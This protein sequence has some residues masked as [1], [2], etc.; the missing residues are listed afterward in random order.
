[1][2]ANKEEAA[3]A[4]ELAEK[5]LLMGDYVGARKMALKA[6]QL[7]PD[8]DNLSRLLVVCDVHC[9]AASKLNGSDSDWYAIL[10][11][12]RFSDETVIL[13]QYRK[14]A[15]SLHPDKNKYAGAEAA[16]K[17][18]GEA[19][20]ELT[21]P[22]RRALFDAKCRG[23]AKSA[24]P[25]VAAN[26]KGPGKKPPGAFHQDI[27]GHTQ[28]QTQPEIMKSHSYKQ[29]QEQTFWTCCQSCKV[30][31]QYYTQ[32]RNKM[33][34]CQ[35][36]NQN[37]VA[38]D[39]VTM[40]VPPRSANSGSASHQGVNVQG[41][42]NAA[43]QSNGDKSTFAGVDLR[44]NG[45]KAT[46]V[47][48][49]PKVKEA[50]ANASGIYST[51]KP[52]VK[53]DEQVTVET[54]KQSSVHMCAAGKPSRSS[55][56]KRPNPCKQ[57][58]SD[59]DFV[60]PPSKRSQEKKSSADIGKEMKKTCGGGILNKKNSSG[61]ASPVADGNKE[62]PKQEP[63]CVTE[64]SLYRKKS[65][66][67]GI[68]ASEDEAS[69]SENQQE[70]NG[71]D[72]GHEMELD[73]QHIHCPDAEFSDF[74]KDKSEDCFKL[75]QVWAL[76]DDIDS[77]PRFYAQIK[78][79]LSPDFKL[80]VN[81]LEA[82]PGTKEEECWE[83]GDLP[84]SCGTFVIGNPEKIKDRLMFSHQ[85]DCRKGKGRGT[86]IIY[87]KK[88]ETWALFKD[89]DIKWGSE[90]DKHKPPYCYDFVEILSDFTEEI[91]VGVACL[92]KV[93]GFVSIFQRASRDKLISFIIT[94][95]E[96]YRFSHRIPSCKMTGKEGEG[97][98]AWSFE[99]DTAALPSS[100]YD[101]NQAQAKEVHCSKEATSSKSDTATYT[102]DPTSTTQ[103]SCTSRISKIDPEGSGMVCGLSAELPD[104]IRV[105]DN[106]G[107]VGHHTNKVADSSQSQRHFV[108][109]KYEDVEHGEPVSTPRRSTR[110]LKKENA[111]AIANQ[112][113]IV[114][115]A[116]NRKDPSTG[117]NHAQTSGSKSDAAIKTES[118]NSVGSSESLAGTPVSPTK[119]KLEAAKHDFNKERSAEKFKVGQV[120]AIFST[121][122]RM[123]KNYAVVKK[124]E[125]APFTL[126]VAM[127]ESTSSR[128][129][130]DRPL[131][132]GS[133]RVGKTVVV[134]VAQFSHLVHAMSTGKHRYMIMPKEGEIW[135]VYKKLESK[136]GEGDGECEIVKVLEEKAESIKV[137]TLKKYSGLKS[138]YLEHK[139]KR[140]KIGEMDIPVEE[141]N[142][143]SHQCAAYYHGGTLNGCWE[144]EASSV[145]SEVIDLE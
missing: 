76:Y 79:I 58:S 50:E 15:L 75:N 115:A 29:P 13:K 98:P 144:V 61:S 95:A 4:R 132:C 130:T 25:K 125:S 71:L 96:L 88:G 101:I 62:E 23:L 97:V 42:S 87:P 73:S 110:G 3:R 17:I 36:C 70:E 89:W 2:E 118:R 120:W 10:Q 30:K 111:D 103:K 65:R 143:F 140:L 72:S 124:I 112:P 54:G 107:H 90:P 67:E 6:Q 38:R 53:A 84:I 45:G 138:F 134:S 5:K 139:S 51:F 109:K 55:S 60:A 19:K 47:S 66:T 48:G 24:A 18:I 35:N 133:F 8:T 100:V 46:S 136:Q 93:E 44:S 31:F 85:M 145:P 82:C 41:S 83:D 102:K 37:F 64:E 32:F 119:W 127:L 121:E 129:G 14:L 108:S 1:M 43:P 57:R 68:Q 106:Q 21:D 52:Q 131:S 33:L 40:G 123:P 20:R 86:Y 12:A 28:Q 128:S 56:K 80:L 7:F 126:H 122:G 34:K 141:I 22:K 9:S 117:G 94:P 104:G 63:E 26:H 99:L 81:W 142:R 74:E 116:K 78:K 135:A 77:M 91:G 113:V 92:G 39:L 11:I 137:V 69:I 59:D 49:K 105:E 16:F 114:E 27:R